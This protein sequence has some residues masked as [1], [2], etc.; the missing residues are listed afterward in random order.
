MLQGKREMTPAEREAAVMKKQQEEEAAEL[1]RKKREEDA[2]GTVYSLTYFFTN[3]S[4]N[5]FFNKV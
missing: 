4:I 5:I 2:P 1:L 3:L